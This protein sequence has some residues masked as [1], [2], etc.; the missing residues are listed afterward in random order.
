MIDPLGVLDDFHISQ[1]MVQSGAFFSYQLDRH[2][3]TFLEL[4]SAFFCLE[5]EIGNLANDFDD[6]ENR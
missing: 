4:P 2:M 3:D 5:S 6:A 1:R